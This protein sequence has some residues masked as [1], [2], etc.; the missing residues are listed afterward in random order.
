MTSIT[1]DYKQAQLS[2]AA[3]GLNLLPGMSNANQ[4]ISYN[5]ALEGAGFSQKQAEVFISKYSVVD[6]YTDSSTGLSATVFSDSGGKTYLAIRGSEN[7]FVD[8]ADWLTNFLDIGANGIAINQ[9]LALLNYM[10]RLTGSANTEIPQYAW[11]SIDRTITSSIITL[12]LKGKLASL[13]GTLSVAGHSLGGHLAMMLSRMAPDLVGS[14]Y[15]YNA[16]GFDTTRGPQDNPLT[17]AGFY[18]ALQNAG[19]TPSTGVVGSGWDFGKISNWY[20]PGDV[21]HNIG[22][23][24]GAR[25][26]VFSESQNTGPLDAH[27][28]KPF[29][30]ALAV[31]DLFYTLDNSADIARLTPI[32]EAASVVQNESLENIVNALGKLF[33]ASTQISTIDDRDQL[34]N[35]VDELKNDAAFSPSGVVSMHGITPDSNAVAA[36]ADKGFLYA[37]EELNPFAVVGKDNLYSSLD[38]AKYTRMYLLDRA[39]LLEDKLIRATNDLQ[40]SHVGS[41]LDG[42]GTY[43]E[44]NLHF[45]D[46]LT[47]YDAHKFQVAVPDT[48]RSFVFGRNN[49]VDTLAGTSGIDHLYGRGGNDSLEGFGKDDYLEGGDGFDTYKYTSGDGQDVVFD[50][51]GAGKI[52]Y[53]GLTLTGGEGVAADADTYRDNNDFTF[54]LGPVVPSDPLDPSVGTDLVISKDGQ[55]G[56]LTIKNFTDGDLGISLTAYQPL[57]P[58]SGILQSDAP[59]I[60]GDNND[61][62]LEGLGSNNEIHG[63]DGNDRIW[64]GGGDDIIF[65]R[66]PTGSTYIP[67]LTNDDDI[68][69]GGDGADTIFGGE[70]DD[71]IFGE[72]GNDLLYAGLGNDYV[73][74][75]ADPDEI[76]GYYGSDIIY[77]GTGGD[78]IVGDDSGAESIVFDG[79]TYYAGSDWLYGQAGND[80]IEGS[81]GDDYLYGGAGND[82][83]W[84]D[85]ANDPTATGDDYL[86][87]GDGADTMRGGSGNDT[88]V[89]GAGD[90]ILFGEDGG[91]V[92]EGGAGLDQMDG[93]S[94]NDVISGGADRDILIA[95]FGDDFLSGD[96]GDDD[97]FGEVGADVLAGGSGNDRLQGGS[98]SDTLQGDTGQ[99]LLFG[100]SGDDLLVGGDGDDQLDGGAGADMLIG[101]KGNDTLIADAGDTI[102]FRAGDGQDSVTLS[103]MVANIEFEGI[104]PNALSVNQVP[105]TNGPRYLQLGFGADSL[106]I[107]DGYLASSQLYDFG[108]QQLNQA[109]L[110]QYSS[111][112][113]VTGTTGNDIIYGSNQ[114]DSISGTDGNDELYGQDGNDVLD[115]G[116]G[117]DLLGGGMGDDTLLGGAGDDTYIVDSVNDIVL[118][119]P[120]SG[121][122]SVDSSADHVLS[123]GV[124]NLTLTGTN[125]ISGSGNDLDNFIQ[126]NGSANTLEGRAGDDTLYAGAGDDRIQGGAGNDKLY[127]GKHDDVYVLGLNDGADR[128]VDLEGFNAIEFGTGIVPSSLSASTFQGDD[129]AFY[130]RLDYGTAGD[131]VLIKNG[132]A[133]AIR[134]YRFLHDGSVLPHA[135]VVGSGPL[136][137][138]AQGTLNDDTMFGGSQDDRL[139]G[140]GGDDS[141][142]G[143]GGNDVLEG[144]TGSDVL[145][146]GDGDD[147]LDG[148][149]GDDTLQGG[150][151]SDT[152]VLRWGMGTDTVIETDGGSNILRLEDGIS[153]AELS[154]WQEGDDLVVRLQGSD[155]G[156]RIKDYALNTQPWKVETSL[157]ETDLLSNLVG[158]LPSVGT[159]DDVLQRYDDQVRAV[160][161]ADLGQDGYVRAAD[162]SMQKTTNSIQT[163]SILTIHNKEDLIV[164]RQNSDSLFVNRLSAATDRQDTT[165]NVTQ[166]RMAKTATTIGQSSLNSQGT[167]TF[168]NANGFS[169]VQVPLGGAVV[170]VS[171]E[172]SLVTGNNYGTPDN[173]GLQGY[174]AFN[175]G[176]EA[177]LGDGQQFQVVTHTEKQRDITTTLEK[178]TGGDS[179]NII[180]S[181]GYT[182]IDGGAGNDRI[183][184][185]GGQFPGFYIEDE[186]DPGNIGSLLYGNDGNDSLFGSNA[187][188]FLTGGAGDDILNGRF[189]ADTYIVLADETGTDLIADSGVVRSHP[190]EEFLTRYTD[191]FYQSLGMTDWENNV[192]NNVPLSVLPPNIA[193]NDFAAL[194]PLYQAGVYAI[195]T[196]E[197]GAG[198]TPD[199][200]SVSLGQFTPE[201]DQDQ[202]YGEVTEFTP[203]AA[204]EHATLDITLQSGG[205]TRVL[206]PNALDQSVTAAMDDGSY[207]AAASIYLGAGIEQFRFADGTF[208]SMTEMLAL[209]AATPPG[210]VIIGGRGEDIL[211][212]GPGDDTLDGGRGADNMAGGAGSDIYFVDN[213]GDTVTE[214]LNEGTDTVSSAVTYM[215]GTNV[216]NLT[217]TGTSGINGTG[218]ALDNQLV[219]NS[220]NNTLTGNDGNDLLVGGAGRDTLAGGLG[221]DTFVINGTDSTYDTVSGGDGLDTILGGAGDD[222]FRFY[223]FKGANTV[224][225][226]DGGA[227]VNTIAGTGSG[228]IID[229]SGTN[230]VNIERIEGGAGNDRL[231][232]SAAADLLVGGAGRDTLAGGLGD[233]VYRFGRGAGQD[234]LVDFDTSG[235][236]DHV[237][238][239]AGIATDQLWFSQSKADLLVSVVGTADQIRVKHWYTGND[240]RTE[241]FHVSDGSI[242]MEGQVQQLVDAMAA[243]NPPAAGQLTLPADLQTRLEP[244]IASSWQSA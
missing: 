236:T 70:G 147:I 37:L 51:D 79:I 232:G 149:T 219:G 166:S 85:L 226:I 50:S 61:N 123:A 161:Y 15:T 127:G 10:Q 151:G 59:L 87:G 145:D 225:T 77:G 207:L 177:N 196:V 243:F 65:G 120:D 57:P 38:P 117:N 148:G 5:L 169:G 44:Q 131:Y 200:I 122:D 218:N 240:Y 55:T 73:D 34:Y 233:D 43:S 72:S 141:L 201:Q 216:E 192:I 133:G 18:A 183:T 25:N 97:L 71:R 119:N 239:D 208:L 80:A 116:L 205:V 3:Y 2:M 99:D 31:Y 142:F 244:V 83:L 86:S 13:Q 187:N 162:G 75:G 237:D 24:P 67:I 182:L 107:E 167:G 42:R 11:N 6:Q 36:K 230:L 111:S 170:E 110:M 41:D 12:T 45:V 198:I 92:M 150:N 8:A 212:G 184:V 47:G 211:T 121:L 39:T 88:L 103:D 136:P 231:T 174:W 54:S 35:L 223:R 69:H 17:S 180:L 210:E 235:A 76:Y 186:L 48:E 102:I 185:H 29:V 93:G 82:F 220:G 155:E 159:L 193:R 30:D 100:E 4:T 222:T 129:G 227:G 58:P 191:W 125:A 229:L 106:A 27:V 114:E 124:E 176:A 46:A 156:L 178:I 96:A 234:T 22:F 189:G 190:E 53:D 195:D 213:S 118:E 172:E 224:E 14:V 33:N 238:F 134:E 137:I 175:S 135:D 7:P 113:N 168:Y 154:S 181:E 140:L 1:E 52:E 21:V 66:K 49:A 63:F 202:L 164:S 108:G 221:D 104:S 68:L 89:G 23:T 126:G 19:I 84:G 242:L 139:K 26:Q 98:G 217:L 115:G 130:L 78:V 101:G 81:H 40:Q 152:Y 160:F 95:G 91:D 56:S 16:P 28:I 90:D 9:G 194:E 112:I 188:D 60:S 105:G 171:G 204:T 209:I 179:T 203:F 132:L 197:F 214:Q 20:L 157:D 64:G 146:G 158:Q 215:L 206:L 143:A 74:G 199:N 128:I 62:Y 165:L 228:D 109:T 144:G 163:S 153:L 173:Y 138:L 32:F 241:E 94:G